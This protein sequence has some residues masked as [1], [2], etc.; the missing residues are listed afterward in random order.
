MAEL[1]PHSQRR[2]NGPE[3]QGQNVPKWK[4]LGTSLWCQGHI[5]NLAPE[6]EVRSVTSGRGALLVPCPH[7][8]VICSNS[9]SQAFSSRIQVC[10]GLGRFQPDFLITLPCSALKCMMG[11]HRTISKLVRVLT[12]TETI[13]LPKSDTLIGK[14]TEPTGLNQH[15]SAL[16]P[17]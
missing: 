11:R 1:F 3:V 15:A 14:S 2:L 16:R 4:A 12:P 9:H 13:P 10:T 17:P 7:L 5:S 8:V 6:P